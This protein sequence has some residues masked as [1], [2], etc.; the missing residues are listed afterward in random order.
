MSRAKEL[1]LEFFNFLNKYK[2]VLG[3]GIP[4]AIAIAVGVT[5][6]FTSADKK[7]ELAWTQLWNVVR[8]Q[9][10]AI[11]SGEDNKTDAISLAVNDYNDIINNISSDK[12]N[13]WAL[14][15]LANTYYKAKN[16]D[17]AL[18]TYDK[19]LTIYQSHYLAPFVKQ[20]IAY[21]YEAKGEYQ[22]A[23]DQFKSI[24]SEIIPAQISLDIG[25]CYEKL[26]MVQPAIDAYS[27]VLKLDQINDN[28]WLQI[29]QHR[30]NALR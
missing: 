19:F 4:A 15:Q 1:R 21:I 29:A 23:I 27:N 10:L 11:Q 24:K 20:S 8:K 9:D 28:N 2:I 25:R 22:K 26:G 18:K 3:V 5:M 6:L 14:Y 17:E 13:S 7:A 12:V 30:I 16:Y